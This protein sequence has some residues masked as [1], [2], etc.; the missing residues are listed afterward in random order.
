ML[1]SAKLQSPPLSV[2]VNS[3]YH[4]TT[5]VLDIHSH[6]IHVTIKLLE[7]WIYIH[8]TFMSPSNYWSTG[9]TFTQHSCHHQTTGVLDIH[10]H[11]IHVTIKLLEYW[12][13]IHTTF[14][15]PSNY[16]STG[17]TFTQ[18]PCH[19]QTTGVLDIHSQR[20]NIS[21]QKTIFYQH[22]DNFCCTSNS[23]VN[24]LNTH[25]TWKKHY[26]FAL[27]LKLCSCE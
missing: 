25:K 5:G 16:W 26:L 24:I 20:N 6:N 13:Y 12:I 1:S 11:N 7:Y 18:H 21:R 23:D 22:D 3:C 4:Q 2:H 10:S 9:Y 19:H 17:Y 14:M 27:I 8:T 15:L